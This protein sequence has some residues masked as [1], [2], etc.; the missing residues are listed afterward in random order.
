[1]TL[2]TAEP[3]HAA[4]ASRRPRAAFARQAL[5]RL[6]V[7]RRLLLAGALGA[8]SLLGDGLGRAFAAREAAWE[9][10]RQASVEAALAER[11]AA[12]LKEREELEARHKAFLEELRDKAE[13]DRKRLGSEHEAKLQALEQLYGQ[14]ATQL[15]LDLQRRDGDLTELRQ[16]EKKWK[17]DKKSGGGLGM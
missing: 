14:R 11:A 7:G 8:A 2:A 9:A 16:A 5:L 12:D 1:M 13:L 17:E 4:S 3:P 10:E 6:F 15:E